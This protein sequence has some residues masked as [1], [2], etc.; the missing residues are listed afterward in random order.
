MKRNI[1][2]LSILLG[3]IKSQKTE[4]EQIKT[5]ELVPET[6]EIR[7]DEDEINE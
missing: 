6:Q 2:V 1:L 5:H 3:T 4:G 7:L